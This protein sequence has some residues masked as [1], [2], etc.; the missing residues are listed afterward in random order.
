MVTI[1]AEYSY[2][3][4][5][6]GSIYEDPLQNPLVEAWLD[7]LES[8][9]LRQATHKLAVTDDSTGENSYCCLGVACEAFGPRHKVVSAGITPFPDQERSWRMYAGVSKSGDPEVYDGTLP[10][11][12]VRAL[13]LRTRV[14]SYF[15]VE[16]TPEKP[17]MALGG[18]I[19]WI[20]SLAVDNDSGA[21]FKDIA[22]TIRSRPPG[23]FVQDSTVEM[24]KY[25]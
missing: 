14:G 12:L 4:V 24:F 20:S 22:T 15:I 16:P 17:S 9:E 23:L 5:E 1:M 8:G 25:A 7:L 2:L 18:K 11:S 21:T 3:R 6:D 19:V 10:S 13:G